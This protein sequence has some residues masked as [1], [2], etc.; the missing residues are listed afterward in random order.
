MVLSIPFPF[1]EVVHILILKTRQVP[2]TSQSSSR[3]L[4]KCRGGKAASGLSI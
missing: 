4:V 1:C 3:K 2:V